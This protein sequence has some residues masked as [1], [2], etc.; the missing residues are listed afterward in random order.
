MEILELK[1]MIPEMKN[2]LDEHKSRLDTGKE[3][4]CQLED[5]QRLFNLKCKGEKRLL[6]KEELSPG[7]L[8]KNNKIHNICIIGIP[9][10]KAREMWVGKNMKK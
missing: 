4:I 9:E 5:K 2:S 1:S 10:Q 8:W 3:W 7:D 6:K